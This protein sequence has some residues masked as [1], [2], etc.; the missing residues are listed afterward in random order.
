MSR[1]NEWD[2]AHSIASQ[3]PNCAGRAK[4][5]AISMLLAT[6]LDLLRSAGT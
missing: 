6:L 5:R 1:P 2:T 4:H 3:I